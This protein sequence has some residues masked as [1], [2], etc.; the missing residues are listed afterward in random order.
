MSHMPVELDMTNI[1]RRDI[2]LSKNEGE[3]QRG[4]TRHHTLEWREDVPSQIVTK[5]W[6]PVLPEAIKRRGRE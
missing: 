4:K 1:Y 5:D 6:V 2:N 3:N